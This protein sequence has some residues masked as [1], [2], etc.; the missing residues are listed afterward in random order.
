MKK[1][2]SILLIAGALGELREVHR[3]VGRA[4]LV[5]I[6]RALAAHKAAY[7]LRRFCLWASSGAVAANPV[8]ALPPLPANLPT[9][10][11]WY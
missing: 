9:K 4:F 8:K 1:T 6:D 7:Y 5:G 3:I 11:P 2:G 10:R